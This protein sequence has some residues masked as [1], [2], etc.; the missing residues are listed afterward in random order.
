MAKKGHDEQEQSEGFSI[1]KRTM[2]LTFEGTDY[3]GAEIRLR[4]D[5]SM[6]EALG[7]QDNLAELQVVQEAAADKAG[8]NRAL[9][10]LLAPIFRQ[11]GDII[12]V[13]WNLQNDEGEAIPATSEGML[14]L[15]APF[16]FLIIE[17]WA[18][19]VTTPPGPLSETSNGSQRSA[20]QE[21]D[22]ADWSRSL[23]PSPEPDS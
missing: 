8:G 19:V 20:E 6:H 14:E 21:T 4:L 1:P 7:I 11:F 5:S 22:L 18:Q 23:G 16:A 10:R 9:T 13:D 2:V 3:E 12:V 17:Q 15:P